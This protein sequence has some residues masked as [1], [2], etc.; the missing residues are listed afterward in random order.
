M[1]AQ[2]TDPKLQVE[3]IDELIDSLHR[4]R[5]S[6]D[7]EIQALQD[8]RKAVLDNPPGSVGN[9]GTAATEAP[10]KKRR[11]RPP[12][13]PKVPGSGRKRGLFARTQDGPIENMPILSVPDQPLVATEV[14]RRDSEN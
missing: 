14:A 9:A 10:P 13:S 3:I 12:G 4:R 6:I 1:P 2:E 7:I 5:Q 8:R 11:G